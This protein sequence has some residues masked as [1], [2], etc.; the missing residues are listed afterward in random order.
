MHVETNRTAKEPGHLLELKVKEVRAFVMPRF[1]FMNGKF[2]I[3]PWHHH[4]GLKLHFK[5]Y[6]DGTVR[7]GFEENGYGVAETYYTMD[8]LEAL[9][10]PF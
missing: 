4:D 5:K 2:K 7:V 3:I 9:M 1:R 10:M 6:G 8:E